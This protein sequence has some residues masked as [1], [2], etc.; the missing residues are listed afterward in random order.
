MF[1]NFHIQTFPGYL[2][3]EHSYE[4]FGKLKQ[5]K[6]KSIPHFLKVHDMPLHFYARPSVIPVFANWK[7]FE[8][9]FHLKK[10]AITIEV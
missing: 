7:K 5:W 2:K 3:V 8:E 9:D 4:T 1:L 6:A 10:K